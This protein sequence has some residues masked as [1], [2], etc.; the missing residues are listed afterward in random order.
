MEIHK[1]LNE[2]IKTNSE[3]DNFCLYDQEQVKSRLLEKQFALLT[4]Q[5]EVRKQYIV[6]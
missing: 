6:V 4:R 5:N 2:E 3:E 1:L